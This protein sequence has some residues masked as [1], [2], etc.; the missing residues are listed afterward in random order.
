MLLTY[1]WYRLYINVIL[2][3]RSMFLDPEISLKIHE[4]THIEILRL[5]KLSPCENILVSSGKTIEDIFNMNTRVAK[6]H[7]NQWAWIDY[8]YNIP[9]M[10][11]VALK[12]WVEKKD[13]RIDDP[14]QT[15]YAAEPSI[16][17]PISNNSAVNL[18]VTFTPDVW[19]FNWFV[20]NIDQVCDV[21]EQMRNSI[22][23][24]SDILILSNHATWFNLP[25]I[26]HCLHRIF[27][28]PQENIYTIL[29][30]A[31]THS[32]WSLAGILR[33][34][35]ALKTYPNTDKA[36]TGY[37]Q[38]SMIQMNFFKHISKILNVNNTTRKSRIVLLSPSGTTDKMTSDGKILMQ[39]PALGTE[40]LIKFFIRR[41]GLLGFVV[42][43]NDT[44][45]I[46]S[47]H[48]RPTRWD[49]FVWLKPIDSSNW[50]EKLM[51]S[52]V[53]SSWKIVWEW[54]NS[55]E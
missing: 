8:E 14:N 1:N 53:N 46:P 29:G 24:W 47:G 36:N 41:M 55:N 9:W 50:K 42:G 45:I 25:L 6:E 19:I 16:Y 28:I 38:S 7:P 10:T 13:I 40:T 43:I 5:Q 34:S 33:Y 37:S 39:K 35:N 31:I 27:W 48:S 52:V 11:Q 30:P 49:V 12:K 21:L 26:A 44:A 22:E 2:I 3:I 51:E 20:R 18:L 17:L 23:S 32:H 4:L 15:L 54:N